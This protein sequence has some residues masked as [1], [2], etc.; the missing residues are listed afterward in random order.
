MPMPV[1]V[2]VPVAVPVRLRLRL[3]LRVPMPRTIFAA[4]RGLLDLARDL[5]AVWCTARKKAEQR[6]R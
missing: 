2:A 5:R 1:A 3:R 4:P 6:R